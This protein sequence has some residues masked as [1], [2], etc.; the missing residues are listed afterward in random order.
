MSDIKKLQHILFEFNR[1]TKASEA[2]KSICEVYDVKTIL[3]STR[4]KWL[5][6]RDN[7]VDLIVSPRL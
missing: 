1:R 7:N 5:S 3:L 6:F 4:R 2:A